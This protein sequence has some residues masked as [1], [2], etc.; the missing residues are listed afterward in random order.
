VVL[1]VLVVL[2]LVVIRESCRVGTVF[3]AVG[4]AL[5]RVMVLYHT[6]ALI[7]AVGV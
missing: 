7:T 6:V 2:W 5:C 3:V 1:V 4:V